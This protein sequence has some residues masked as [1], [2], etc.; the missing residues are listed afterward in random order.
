MSESHGCRQTKGAGL[1]EDAQR[2][3]VD[4]VSGFAKTKTFTGHMLLPRMIMDVSSPVGL[5]IRSPPDPPR[6]LSIALA[7]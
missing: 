1:L 3:R 5:R 2:R 6:P 4:G 7:C